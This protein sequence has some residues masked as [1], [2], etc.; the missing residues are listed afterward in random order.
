MLTGRQ[1]GLARGDAR[2]LR[3]DPGYGPFA[4]ARDASVEAQAGLG[5]L[6]EGDR[7]VLW[8]A[9]GTERMPPRLCV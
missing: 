3:I 5:A 7:D 9:E 2:A 1:A 8:L 4:A 6:L